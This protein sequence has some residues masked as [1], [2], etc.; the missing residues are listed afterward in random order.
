MILDKKGEFWY[1]AAFSIE[2]RFGSRGAEGGFTNG[3]KE[4]KAKKK[5]KQKAKSTG[6]TGGAP[7][8]ASKRLSG[9]GDGEADK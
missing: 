9:S 7:K 6:A 4:P 8:L 2:S 1:I 5:R 3:Q